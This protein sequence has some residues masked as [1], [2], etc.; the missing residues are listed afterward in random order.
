MMYY[1]LICRSLTY[2]QR[3]KQILESAGI[4][5]TVTRVPQEIT[6]EGCGYC[7]KVAGR[8]FIDALTILKNIETYPKRV[9]A[10]YDDGTFIEVT[11]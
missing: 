1:L 3:A 5:A 4:T 11:V 10:I 2:A 6:T 8:H 7:V 9:F